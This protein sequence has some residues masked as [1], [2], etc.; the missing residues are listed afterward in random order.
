MSIVTTMI[1][2]FRGPGICTLSATAIAPRSPENH[3]TTWK[4]FEILCFERGRNAMLMPCGH[5]FTCSECVAQLRQRE[6]PVCRCGWRPDD[7]AVPVAE[8]TAAADDGE[9]RDEGYVN[10][11]A[12]QPGTQAA[13]DDSSYSEWLE[14]HRRRREQAALAPEAVSYT[15]LT[16][17]TKA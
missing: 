2:P 17:P 6:C 4:F 10:L 5:M 3:I 11:G 7:P 14:L 15:H 13:R 1:G 8:A 16:L 9:R 12:L